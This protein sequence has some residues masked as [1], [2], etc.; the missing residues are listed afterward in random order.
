MPHLQ[1][2]IS[3]QRR[4]RHLELERDASFGVLNRIDQALIIF[5]DQGRPTYVNFSAQAILEQQDGLTI[6]P[7][8]LRAA[9]AAESRQ[10]GILIHGAIQTAMGIGVAAGGALAI[11]R[12]SLRRP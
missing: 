11:S 5:D 8:G 3:I 7:E 9:S 6:H 12:P 1:R 4:V 10:L 2:S